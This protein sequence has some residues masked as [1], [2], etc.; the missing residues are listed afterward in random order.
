MEMDRVQK[1]YLFVEFEQST[2]AHLVDHIKHELVRDLI[3]SNA[4]CPRRLDL[5]PTAGSI[6]SMNRF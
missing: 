1:L 6:N 3:V 5:T 4:E 2:S